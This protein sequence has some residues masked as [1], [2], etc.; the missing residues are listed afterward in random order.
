MHDCQCSKYTERHTNTNVEPD[1][2]Y[3][4]TRQ[5]LVRSMPKNYWSA[6]EKHIY[7]SEIVVQIKT[8]ATLQL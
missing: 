2:N 7:L 8:F 4:G 6:E 5:I 3:N 1:H